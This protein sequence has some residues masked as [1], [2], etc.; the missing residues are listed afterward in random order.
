MRLPVDLSAWKS[1]QAH[2]AATRD[3]QMRDLFA[4]DPKRAESLSLRWNDILVDYSKN[5]VTAETLSLLRQL[6]KEAKVE[7]WRDRMFRGEKINFTENRSVLHIAL[8]R[9]ADQPLKVDGKDVM[10]E[11]EKV[12]Q[13]MKAFSEKVRSGEWKGYTGQPV[14]DIVNIGI[15]GSDLGPVMV[16]EALKPYARRDLKLQNCL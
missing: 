5:R 12:R 11:V 7:E 6:L 14:S 16:T 10:P 15:G 9:P 3:L 4:K 2:A 13:Q 1:L 8:R